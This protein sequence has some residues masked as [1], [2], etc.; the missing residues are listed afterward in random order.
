MGGK[1]CLNCKGKILL[2]IVNKLLKTKHLLTSPITPQANIPA[3]KLSFHWRWRWWDRIQA[4]FK[5]LFYFK[6]NWLWQMDRLRFSISCLWLQGLKKPV[7]LSI[8][9]WFLQFSS[10]KYRVWWTWFLVYVFQTWILHATAGRKIQF[11]L[12]KKSSTSNLIIQTGE[13]QK[14]SVDKLGN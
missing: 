9:T 11:K 2:G 1:V 5:N 13:L 10:L 6:V 14:S 12:G 8:Y 4:T 3:H 7:P